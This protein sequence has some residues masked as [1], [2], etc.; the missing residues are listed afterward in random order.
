[1]DKNI[2]EEYVQINGIEQYFLHQPSDSKDVV[3]MLHGGPGLANS[4]LAYFQQPYSGFCNMVY[5]DQRGA[6]KTQIKNQSTHESLTFD[7]LLEDLRQ[8]IVYIKKKYATDRIFLAGHSWGS[9][10]GTEYVLRYKDVAGYIGYGQGVPG[11]K[12]DRRYYEFVKS[13]V[14]KSGNQE[15]MAT[16]DRVSESFPDVPRDDYF[17]QYNIISGIGFGCGYDFTSRDVFEI[18]ANSPT[19]TDADE[20]LS[21]VV[22]ELN[23]K[24]YAEVLFDWENKTTVYEIPVFY[25]LGIHDEM[26]SSVIAEEYFNQIQAP[27]KGLYWIENAGHLVDTDNPSDFFAAVKDIVGVC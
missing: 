6:G 16:L 14:Q 19:W 11:N 17:R 3:I 24:L 2:V 1:M 22:E 5:Y 25:I 12:Q 18:Y 13:C 8:T 20:E 26:T 10:L 27:K 23:E 9:M 4:Y 7:V 15:Q 21:D